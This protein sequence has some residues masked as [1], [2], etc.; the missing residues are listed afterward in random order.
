[1]CPNISARRS[2]GRLAGRELGRR[3]HHNYLGR[4]QGLSGSRHRRH[5]EVP[6]SNSPRASYG[7]GEETPS[8]RS[9][10]RHCSAVWLATSPT[11][12][13]APQQQPAGELRRGYLPSDSQPESSSLFSLIFSSAGQRAGWDS[14]QCW[15]LAAHLSSQHISLRRPAA[16]SCCQSRRRPAR[17]PAAVSCCQ[18][19]RPAQHTNISSGRR[20][21]IAERCGAT[22]LTPRDS[23]R[24]AK[25]KRDV[26]RATHCCDPS[27]KEKSPG[28]AARQAGRLEEE[29]MRENSDE[30]SGWG[31]LRGR[32]LSVARPRAVAVGHFAMSA[33]SRARQPS[34]GASPSEPMARRAVARRAGELDGETA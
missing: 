18:S 6:H 11:S 23:S 25:A 12:R 10:T 20:R 8:A 33:M 5:R 31:C 22:L 14:R 27:W 32:I 24:S 4:L 17:R 30:L 34:S 28:C 21:V 26:L 15:W 3:C 7:D 13:S 16:V 29:K 9:A 2:S 19:R 1:M